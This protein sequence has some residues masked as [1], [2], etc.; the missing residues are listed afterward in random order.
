MGIF[1]FNYFPRSVVAHKDM[2]QILGHKGMTVPRYFSLPQA[3]CQLES[4]F[5]SKLQEHCMSGWHR[6]PDPCWDHVMHTGM[7]FSFVDINS[8]NVV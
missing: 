8:W 3:A 6:E 4:S 5:A 2:F 7:M 1:V